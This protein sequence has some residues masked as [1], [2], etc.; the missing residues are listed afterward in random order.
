[1]NHSIF[2]R[3]LWKEYRLQRALWIA[4]FA[5][6]VLLQLLSVALLSSQDRPLFLFW[7]A[8]GLSA[9]YFLGC[10]AVLFAGEQEAGTYEF[11]RALPVAAGRVFAAKM[12]LAI[13]GALA[14]LGGT[15]LLAFALS[16]WTFHPPQGFS[17]LAFPVAFGFLGLEMFLWAALFS[18]LSKRVLVAAILGV[19]AASVVAQTAS[20]SISPIV[21]TYQYLWQTIPVRAVAAA[22]VAAADCW[23][24]LQWFR[25]KTARRSRPVGCWSGSSTA[26][27]TAV[28]L[29][30]AFRKSGGTTML[31]R[32]LWQHWRQSRWIMV[33][34]GAMDVPLAAF[35]MRWL[36]QTLTRPHAPHNPDP[37]EGT[38]FTLAMLLALASVPLFGLCAFLPDQWRRGY[39][40]LADRGVPPKYVWL[41]RQLVAFG[42]PLLLLAVLLLVALV[43]GAVLLPSPLPANHPQISLAEIYERAYVFCGFALAAVGYAAL[44]IAVGQFASMFL[45]SGLLAGLLSVL[46]S[47]LLVGWCWLMWLWQVSW[48]WSVLPIPLALLLATRLR[49]RD[50]L[51]ERN[52]PRAWFPSVLVLTVPLATILTAV[53]LYRVYSVPVIDPGFALAEY[54]RP[55]TPEEQTTLDLYRQ[56][57]YVYRPVYRPGLDPFEPLTHADEIAWINSN[58]DAIAL[59]MKISERKYSP[60]VG[61]RLWPSEDYGLADLLIHSAAILEAEGKLDAAFEQYL[62]AVR[63][64]G[65][66]RA[67]Y[68]ITL[69]ERILDAK[70]ADRIEIEVYARLPS[71]A[72]RRGQTPERVLAAM[73]RLEQTTS[74]MPLSDGIKMAHVCIRRF[75][76]GQVDAINR[77]G[78]PDFQPVPTLSLLWM[79]LPWERARALRV[80]DRVTRRQ[81]DR[82][83]AA[84][85]TSRRGEAIQQPPRGPRPYTDPWYREMDFPYALQTEVHVPPVC[86]ALTSMQDEMVRAFTAIETAR[87]AT[88]LLL[89]IEAWKIQHGS[90]PKTLDQ[91][92]GPCLDRLPADPYSGVSFRYFRGGL[93]DSFRWSQPMLVR[94][95]YF[96]PAQ[97]ARDFIGGT[98]AAGTPLVWSTGEK[99]HY[100]PPPAKG[101][102]AQYWLDRDDDEANAYG[103]AFAPAHYYRETN[104]TFEIWSSGWPFPIP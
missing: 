60:L 90:L 41:S 51:L 97:S 102:A 43:I 24:G 72:A 75:L 79:R 73:R 83:A 26:A 68:P 19:A 44:G 32:L 21:S 49:T 31:G 95:W 53:P 103:R 71:W 59:A 34:V 80:L 94:F 46:L 2:W 86:Y 1:M 91:L 47:S 66:L 56:A 29:S 98:I 77:I 12:T 36:T 17:P 9:F 84:E 62:G 92:V 25:E 76:L 48:P 65:Q 89:A 78:N 20:I 70:R 7:T 67:W 38:L 14:M 104:S 39:R 3:L 8:S 58:R 57:P 99:V 22:I 74:E 5:M 55:M 87:R 23:L 16:G 33:V 37:A 45:R 64:S 81:L 63:I 85:R 35:A 28:G 6:T 40:F 18:L 61:D 42:P 4:M 100:G 10:G 54:D 50:W 69:H 13:L 15:W 30:A 93:P 52:T 101:A 27:P 96:Q 11:Q 88:R 82:L